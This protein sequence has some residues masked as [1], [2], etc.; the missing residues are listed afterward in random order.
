MEEKRKDC[1]FIYLTHDIDF[2]STRIANKLW[3]KSYTC[4]A[5]RGVRKIWEI[6]Q[7]IRIL[8]SPEAN[9]DEN[10][11]KSKKSSCFVKGKRVVWIDKYSKCCSRNLQ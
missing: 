1:M 8:K 3:L 6:E 9:V 11:G 7:N 2:A 4:S 5:F 10:T